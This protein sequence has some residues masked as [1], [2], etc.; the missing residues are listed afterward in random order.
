MRR[1]P[2]LTT[3]TSS[4]TTKF[5]YNSDDCM[6]LKVTDIFLLIS[7]TNYFKLHTDL[8]VILIILL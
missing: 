2:E 4:D 7:G 5:C 6:N 8:Y 1:E 3:D